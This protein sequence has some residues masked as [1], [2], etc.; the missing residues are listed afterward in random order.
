MIDSASTHALATISNTITATKSVTATVVT[1]S[2]SI[3]EQGQTEL[4]TFSWA[5]GQANYA[6][7]IIVTNAV[8]GNVIANIINSGLSDHHKLI[9]IH[10]PCNK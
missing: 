8:N 1:T 5:G 2:N 4:L 7:N 9:R 10:R 6:A 3:V